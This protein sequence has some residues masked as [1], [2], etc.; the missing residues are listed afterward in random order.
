MRKSDCEVGAFPP[1]ETV[2]ESEEIREVLS[3]EEIQ[4]FAHNTDRLQDYLFVNAPKEGSSVEERKRFE[5]TRIAIRRERTAREMS[6]DDVWTC[7]NPECQAKNRDEAWKCKDCCTPDSSRPYVMEFFI[8]E[9][10]HSL[11]RKAFLDGKIT[12]R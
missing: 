9:N 6:L 10:A 1:R 3:P 11:L 4:E 5:K 12:E 7:P 2:L 8:K